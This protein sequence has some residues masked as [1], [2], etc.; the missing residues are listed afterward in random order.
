[1]NTTRNALF[2]CLLVLGCLSAQAQDCN[3][4]PKN[5]A[6]LKE[7]RPQS[8]TVEG[9]LAEFDPCHRSTKFQKPSVFSKSPLMIV[10]HGGG[11]LDVATRNA[12]DGFRSKGFA[13]LIFDAYEH[14]GFNQGMQFWGSKGTNE[15]RQRMLYKV[16]MSAYEWALKRSDIDVNQIYFHGI[17]NGGTVLLNIAGAVSPNHVKGIFAEGGPSAGLGLPDKINVPLRLVY[18][19]LDNYAG[20]AEDDF[21]WLRKEI[22]LV[23]VVDFNHPSGTSKTCSATANPR[24]LSQSVFEWY[25]QQK[26][27][28]ADIDVWFYENAAHGIF[29]GPM[30]KNMITY[31]VDMRRY[32]WVGGDPSAKSKLLDDIDRFRKSKP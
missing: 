22:C 17:S 12:A 1:M 25:E 2:T 20:K 4:A 23:N 8:F 14:N 28:G 13:T 31:G 3:P 24:G 32:A 6:T 9:P 16:A 18:G 21:V 19:K 5:V 27:N 29:L 10:L 11:G 26:R 7:I 30:Q 15:A